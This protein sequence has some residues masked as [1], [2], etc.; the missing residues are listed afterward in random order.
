MSNGFTEEERGRLP[1]NIRAV[2][3]IN[4]KGAARMRHGTGET[5]DAELEF[6]G[7]N[8]DLTRLRLA[9]M[10][11]DILKRMRGN[12]HNPRKD[13]LVQALKDLS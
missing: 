7:Q 2:R 11:K 8:N 1:K 6:R 4:E 3:L 12:V 13:K 5:D 9:Q 10:E